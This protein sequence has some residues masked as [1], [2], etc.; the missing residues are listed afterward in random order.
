[1][2]LFNGV[3][4]RLLLCVVVVLLLWAVGFYYAMMDE[5][6]DETDDSLEDYSE[7][8]IVRSLAGDSLPSI[9]N[10]SNNQYFIKEVTPAYAMGRPAISYKDSMVYIVAK[11]ETEPARILTTIFKDSTDRYYELEV[12]IPT[13][14]K[15]DLRESIFHLI[16][17]L[18][19]CLVLTFLLISAFVFKKTMKPFYQMLGWIEKNRLGS[20]SSGPQ[21]DTSTTEFRKLNDALTKYAHHSEEMFQQQKQFIGNASHEIQT[22]IAVCINRIEMLMEDENLSESQLEELLKTYKT[23]EYVSKLNKSLLLLTKIENNQFSEVVEVDFNSTISL[24]LKDYKEVYAYKEME[25]VFQQRGTF[26]AM[27]N[28]T[29]G[30][31]LVANLIKNAFVHT[32][33]KGKIGIIC[34]EE[35]IEFRNTADGGALDGEHIF[36]RFYQFR[37]KEESMG[38]GLA[39]ADAICKSFNLQIMYSWEDGMHSFRVSK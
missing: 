25:I 5:I 3:F 19:L 6:T 8:I 20:G 28:H 18:F 36:E 30:G 35:G 21:V 1:M 37:K 13:I 24:F 12:S 34:S 17:L 27:M 14:E 32:A 22:P 26:K 39:I 10:G 11:K 7:M 38:L 4:L 9:D 16:I 29:L 23:L 2:K 31:I 15:K 33:A